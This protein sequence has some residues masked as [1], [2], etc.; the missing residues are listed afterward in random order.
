MIKSLQTLIILFFFAGNF[1]SCNDNVKNNTGV[2]TNTLPGSKSVNPYA[3]V[4]QSPMDMSYF[5][6]DYGIK[7]MKAIDSFSLPVARVIY[8][9][10]QKKG[11]VLFGNS[12]QSLCQYGKEWRLGANEATEIEFF[13]EVVIAGK[14]IPQG[15]YI[16]YCIPY[17]D[18]WAIVLNSNLFS[19]GLNMDASKDIFKTEILIELQS[20]AL[21]HFTM[22]F[23]TETQGMNLIMA[24]DNV[25]AV[26]PI[27]YAK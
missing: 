15:K 9:R 22:V 26:L 10:P 7:K 20:P 24:W 21:E 8:S 11:R 19:W 12:D 4:D 1:L 27:A 14:L 5:P 18:K 2:A 6:A 17:A 25:K 13:K 16:I 3:A 23:D